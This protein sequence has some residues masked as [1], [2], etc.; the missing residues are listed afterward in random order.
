MSK[1]IKLNDNLAEKFDAL[2]IRLGY[3]KQTDMLLDVCKFFE[4]NPINL[5]QENFKTGFQNL[6]KI[7][8]KGFS[9]LNARITMDFENMNRFENDLQNFNSLFNDTVLKNKLKQSEN[10]VD[11]NK[12]IKLE[13]VID[14]QEKQIKSYQTSIEKNDSDLNDFYK[15]LRTLNL[16]MKV[17]KT[18]IGKKAYIDLPIEEIE[19]LFDIIEN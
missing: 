16:N 7:I 5:R 17:E 6:H 11:E 4:V 18:A 3:S 9:S 13:G 1:M 12:I 10:S 14:K 15:R 8:N 19:I 2:R